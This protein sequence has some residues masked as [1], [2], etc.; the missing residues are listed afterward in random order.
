MDTSVITSCLNNQNDHTNYSYRSFLKIYE[1]TIIVSS[2]PSNDRL[3]LDNV[4][5]GA[6]LKK[7]KG[8]LDA[9]SFADLKRKVESEHAGKGLETYWQKILDTRGKNE[10]L[11]SESIDLK[12]SSPPPIEIG[13]TL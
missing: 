12:I 5:A 8:L 6:F 13:W 4:W 9:N 2:P 7:A 3:N 1:K 10:N 11:K